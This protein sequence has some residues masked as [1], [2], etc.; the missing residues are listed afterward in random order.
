MIEGQLELG[1]ARTFTVAHQYAVGNDYELIAFN[2]YG[3][4]TVGLFTC[5]TK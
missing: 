1:T 2:P 3:D 5:S 4:S